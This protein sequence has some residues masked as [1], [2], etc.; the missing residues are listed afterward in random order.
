M[1]VNVNGRT[2]VGMYKTA[3]FRSCCK[4]VSVCASVCMCVKPTPCSLCTCQSSSPGVTHPCSGLLKISAGARLRDR[5]CSV[6]AW[7]FSRLDEVGCYTDSPENKGRSWGADSRA[8]LEPHCPPLESVLSWLLGFTVSHF[9]H[10][11]G[12]HLV[13]FEWYTHCMGILE[14]SIKERQLRGR[15][16][17]KQNPPRPGLAS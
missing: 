9:C 14:G 5:G 4:C 10:R 3:T 2:G 6:S 17:E 13:P 15:P 7:C 12:C 16:G 1:H 8:G 11:A